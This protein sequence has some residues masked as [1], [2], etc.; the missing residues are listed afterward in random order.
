M[1]FS[2]SVRELGYTSN[3]SLPANLITIFI[4]FVNRHFLGSGVCTK[5]THEPCQGVWTN[6]R[7]A[8]TQ[9]PKPCGSPGWCGACDH[10]FVNVPRDQVIISPSRHSPTPMQEWGLSFLF[11][12]R[13]ALF[14]AHPADSNLR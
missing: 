12:P 1:R 7:T 10:G 13:R 3:I 6:G 2:I 5:K 4:L 14:I 9:N 8:A 11:Q